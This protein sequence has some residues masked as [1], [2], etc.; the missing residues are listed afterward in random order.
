LCANPVALGAAYGLTYLISLAI[1]PCFR[2]YEATSRTYFGDDFGVLG[3]NI[4]RNSTAAVLAIGILQKAAVITASTVSLPIGGAVLLVCLGSCL[5]G[6]SSI[7][8]VT[9]A[10]QE[11]AQES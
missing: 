5:Q 10:R 2:I 4:I 6:L 9:A 7:S 3:I 11:R 1:K 8:E